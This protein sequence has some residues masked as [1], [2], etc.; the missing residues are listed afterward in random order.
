[1]RRLKASLLTIFTILALSTVTPSIAYAAPLAVSDKDWQ[2]VNG[3][4]WAWNYSPQKQITKDNVNQLE[5]KW[6]FPV[7]Q[8]ALAPAVLRTTG[9]IEG[10]TTPPI[11]RNGR[12]FIETNWLRVYAL[13][14]KTGKQLWVNDYTLNITE[15]S[16]RIPA[17]IGRST[18]LHGFRYWEGGNALLV[19]GPLCDFYG[20]D[21][22]TGERVFY[23]P[24]LC[25][26]V[27]GMIHKYVSIIPGGGNEIATYE[28]G[29]QFIIYEPG[30]RGGAIL[31]GR[32]FVAGVDM[33]THKVAWRIFLQPPHDRPEPEWALKNCDIGWFPLGVSCSDAVA[34]WGRDALMYDWQSNPGQPMNGFN[35]VSSSW[36][37]SVVDEDTGILYLPSTGNQSPYTNVTFRPGPNLYGSTIIA[38]D[39]NKGQMVWWLQPYPHDPWDWDCNWSGILVDHPDLGK[40]YAKGCKDGILYVVDASTGKPLYYV[41]ILEDHPYYKGMRTIHIPNPAEDSKQLIYRDADGKEY[42]YTWAEWLKLKWPGYPGNPSIHMIPGIANGP[43]AT[44]MSY[45]PETDTLFHYTGMLPWT[46]VEQYPIVEGERIWRAAINFPH[47]T[48]IVARDLA[49]GKIKWATPPLNTG[50][51]LIRGHMLITG[52]MVVSPQPDGFLRFYDEENGK[53]LRE[54]NLGSMLVTGVTTGQDADGKQKIFGIIG[55]TSQLTYYSSTIPGTVFAIGLSERP[56]AAV[57]TTTVTTTLVTKVTETV[58]LPAEVTYAAVTIAVIAIIAAAIVVA[59][60]RP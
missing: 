54:M 45:D 25:T 35:G 34:K 31:A 5:V 37:Q 19:G 60:R 11:V 57:R 12:V 53:L 51:Q 58:G 16:A 49:T 38:I 3:N 4:S 10:A 41:D 17:V 6:L 15:I 1:M 28:K 27:P 40:I 26:N 14:A 59:R 48:S 39:L 33:D 30:G 36:G 7:G 29:R 55:Q 47:N 2:Y 50:G 42:R 21:A 52:G 56:A 46:I 43:F 22:D 32:A 9:L 13:D 8:K 23:V 20:V 18:H 24:D 44:D